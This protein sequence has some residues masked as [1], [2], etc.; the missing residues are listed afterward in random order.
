MQHVITRERTHRV[1]LFR[2]I[3]L[4]DP[5]E[6][7]DVHRRSGHDR[8]GAHRFLSIDAESSAELFLHRIRR[9]HIDAPRAVGDLDRVLRRLARYVPNWLLERGVLHRRLTVTRHTRSVHRIEI[10]LA[11]LRRHQI[12]RTREWTRE[13][14]ILLVIQITGITGVDI[15]MQLDIELLLVQFLGRVPVE[16]QHRHLRTIVALN[17]L[18]RQLRAPF[19]RVMDGIARTVVHRCND[20]HTFPR[21]HLQP[22][23]TALRTLVLVRAVTLRTEVTD[24][25]RLHRDRLAV[26]VLA[27]HTIDGIT[28]PVDVVIPRPAVRPYGDLKV[29]R[30]RTRG[31]DHVVLFQ[32]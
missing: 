1:P 10:R 32:L 15:Q 21:T 19:A 4:I 12:I 13:T 11:Q 31:I 7:R 9:V 23:R 28:R 20:R 2:H 26:F 6:R 18:D 8:F 30:T 5:M 3:K 27:L 25:V 22:C 24:R 17:L 14:K 29:N 16:L